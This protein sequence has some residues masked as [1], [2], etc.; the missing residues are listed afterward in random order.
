[1][2]IF[3]NVMPV[4]GAVNIWGA[5]VDACAWL[6]QKIFELTMLV[7]IPNYVLAI[8][9]FTCLVKIL[10]QPMMGAQM[11][12]TRKMQQI[13]PQLEELNFVAEKA[14]A[15]LLGSNLFND[16]QFGDWD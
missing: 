10:I 15:G 11:K 6:L 14:I 1:M 16:G 3:A 2:E 12:A 9:I 7:G 5:V 4:V 13:K 8:F